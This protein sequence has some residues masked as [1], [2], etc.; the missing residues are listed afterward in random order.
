[1][2][3]AAVLPAMDDIWQ[4]LAPDVTVQNEGADGIAWGGATTR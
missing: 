1:M 2:Q 3:V 4:Y